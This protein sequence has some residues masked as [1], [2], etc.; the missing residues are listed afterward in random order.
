MKRWQKIALGIVIGLFIWHHPA[1][2]GSVL[3]DG[4]HNLTVF[5]QNVGL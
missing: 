1:H 2:A 5:A 3:H 4:W